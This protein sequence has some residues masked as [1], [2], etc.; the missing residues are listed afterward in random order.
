MWGGIIYHSFFNFH[1]F[2]YFCVYAGVLVPAV[3][4]PSRGFHAKGSSWRLQPAR[5]RK[6][7]TIPFEE[8]SSLALCHH[9]T[10]LPT[11]DTYNFI[12]LKVPA[13]SGDCQLRV[14]GLE[15]NQKYVFAVAAYN[16]QGKLLG[17][18]IGET[19][20][21]L[22]ASMALP[23]LTTWAHLAQVEMLSFEYLLV[24]NSAHHP[25]FHAGCLYQTGFVRCVLPLGNTRTDKDT[26]LLFRFCQMPSY[27]ITLCKAL[28][29]IFLPQ[30]A[31]QSEQYAVAKRACRELWNHY[32]QPKPKLH[33]T[34]ERFVT[35]G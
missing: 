8:R 3:W 15:P 11:K 14:E 24:V 9:L 16:S 19:T 21:P 6:Y 23:L 30:V 13:A 22:L 7:S 32:I 34:E 20:M 27:N 10:C 29:L 25:L 18:T 17:N 28:K 1:S 4:P 33:N 5:N 35:T 26:Q 12:C 31:F 2:F